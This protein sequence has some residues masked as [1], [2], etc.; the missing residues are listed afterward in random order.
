[1]AAAVAAGLVPAAV[2]LIVL[3]YAGHVSV[4][5]VLI[6]LALGAAVSVIW[7]VA[8]ARD[9]RAHAERVEAV[10][11][12][13]ER[14][15]PPPHLVRGNNDELGRAERKLL[16][17]ADAVAGEINTLAEQRDEL[18]AILRSMTEAVVVT[19]RDGSVVLV[20]GAARKMFGLGS[21]AAVQGR[22]FVEFCRDPRLQEFVARSM[23][24]LDGAVIRAQIVIQNPEHHD[25]DVNAA[26]ILRAR[27]EVT[28]WVLVFHDITRLKS[29]ETVR[30]DFIQNLTHELR[31][32]LS[33]L[34]GYAETLMA[35]VDDPATRRRFLSIIDRQSRRLGRLIDDLIA[36]SDLE[37]G[38]T[39]LRLEPLD[40]RAVIDEAAELMR[41]QAQRVGIAIEIDC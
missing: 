12:A 22:D 34:C 7:L 28:A 24:S 8:A 5:W 25:L 40:A 30:A 35:G 2:L 23:A 17:A 32:P 19:R 29:Y 18:E 37:R 1:M 20:N 31:T 16:D 39:P 41:E 11:S 6:A 9:L 36:L 13:L 4:I 33:A 14:R 10:G 3:A 27:G 21:D 26:P 15:M 38:L